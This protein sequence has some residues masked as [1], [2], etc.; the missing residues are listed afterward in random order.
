ME[1]A[2]ANEQ[3]WA[4]DLLGGF[5]KAGEKAV[6]Y[7]EKICEKGKSSCDDSDRGR[8]TFRIYRTDSVQ[9]YGYG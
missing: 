7:T 9:R 3:Q 1:F 6:F 4:G 2:L 8:R 5:S